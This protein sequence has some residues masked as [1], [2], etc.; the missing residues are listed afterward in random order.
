MTDVVSSKI[1]KYFSLSPYLITFPSTLQK[2]ME[3]ESSSLM[4][5]NLTSRVFKVEMVAV[6][7]K[8]RG[9]L[10]AT[11]NVAYQSTAYRLRDNGSPIRYGD[12]EKGEQ[13]DNIYM[14][15]YFLDHQTSAC[16]TRGA[17]KVHRVPDVVKRDH[18]PTFETRLRD[19]QMNLSQLVLMSPED[20]LV[21]T[22]PGSID[23]GQSSQ[24][25]SAFTSS[26]V[27]CSNDF[28]PSEPSRKKSRS[29]SSGSTPL[30][31]SGR[32]SVS[33][34]ISKDTPMF[35]YQTIEDPDYMGIPYK[36]HLIP[37]SWNRPDDIN[38]Y[39]AGSWAFHQFL[40]GLNL[41]DGLPGLVVDFLRA[42]GTSVNADDGVRYKVLIKIRFFD[43]TSDKGMKDQFRE[44]LKGGSV[45]KRDG[46][47]ESF[48]HV[49]DV[50]RFKMNLG[51]KKLI[52]EDAVS[53]K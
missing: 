45:V 5:E 30:R 37:K 17:Q 24:D 47:I 52:T 38:N 4:T 48:V 46:S 35:K 11:Y 8:F 16:F 20:F 9:M 7:G 6:R 22:P 51:V 18:S 39:L 21:F 13:E 32:L 50:E 53:R 33:S 3:N 23:F 2:N 25:L 19:F 28:T 12:Q 49:L 42:D 40:D 44:R 15:V 31:S 1:R 14:N 41:V 36:L 10:G 43:E 26:E 34:T 29:I 27:P